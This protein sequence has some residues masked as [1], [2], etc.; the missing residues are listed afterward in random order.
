M[1]IKISSLIRWFLKIRR[2]I[3]RTREEEYSDAEAYASID[4]RSE[5]Q[6]VVKAIND[7][8]NRLI[9][10][11]LGIIAGSMFMLIGADS[12]QPT[13]W[14]LYFY[15]LFGVGWICLGV[16][17][18]CGVVISRNRTIVPDNKTIRELAM[19]HEKIDERFRRQ[20]SFLYIGFIPLLVWL[21][22]FLFAYVFDRT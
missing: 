6:E 14:I 19:L 10:W 5:F 15:F 22:A 21:T 3:R 11:S 20:I 9:T 17:I 8:S 1:R 16:S 12:T 18:L 7:E 13:G 2:F 4:Q